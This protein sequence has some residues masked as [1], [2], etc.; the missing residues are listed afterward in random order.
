[1]ADTSDD[2]SHIMFVSIVRSSSVV[3]WLMLPMKWKPYD[4]VVVVGIR[5]DMFAKA[6]SA[7]MTSMATARSYVGTIIWGFR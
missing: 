1:M 7:L 5:G 4:S 3:S 2:N 6:S